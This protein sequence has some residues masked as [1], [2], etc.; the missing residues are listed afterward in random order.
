MMLAFR[1]GK[2]KR[3]DPET[4][5]S[6]F[7]N[8]FRSLPRPTIAWTRR[9]RDADTTTAGT[10]YT[11]KEQPGLI[12]TVQDRNPD[13]PATYIEGSNKSEL[14]AISLSRVTS[15]GSPRPIHELL[16]GE[17]CPLAELSTSSN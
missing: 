7:R 14:H 11:Y 15:G 17:N 6:G 5:R 12:P 4:S 10:L 13:L 2:K 3:N 16:A 9:A 8:K 1:M